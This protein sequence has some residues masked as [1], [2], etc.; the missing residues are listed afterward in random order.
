VLSAVSGSA[1]PFTTTMSVIRL[2]TPSAPGFTV[3]WKTHWLPEGEGIPVFVEAVITGSS[4]PPATPTST[5][6]F[7][8]GAAPGEQSLVVSVNAMCADTI[9]FGVESI[10]LLRRHRLT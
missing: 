8:G 4:L 7:D 9:R 2:G 3:T 5:C 10:N 1:P 6:R